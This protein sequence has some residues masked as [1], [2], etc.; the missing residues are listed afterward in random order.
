MAKILKKEVAVQ[1]MYH[2]CTCPLHGYSLH[3]YGG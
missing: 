3:Y 2:L 1:I